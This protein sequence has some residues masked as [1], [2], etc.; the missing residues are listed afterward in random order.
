M[1]KWRINWCGNYSEFSVIFDTKEEAKKLYN[2]LIARNK[3]IYSVH[4]AG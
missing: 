2:S 4:V 1:E 3:K